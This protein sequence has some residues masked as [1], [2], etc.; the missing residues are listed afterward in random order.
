ML[1]IPSFKVNKTGT[2]LVVLVL[3]CTYI[4]LG[5]FLE[6]TQFSLFLGLYF[7]AFV[8]S[9]F[10]YIKHKNNLK[11]LIGSSLLFRILL[12]AAIPNLSQDF[13]RFIWDGR[14]L[15]EGLNPYITT[16]ESW[17]ASHNFPIAQAQELYNGMGDLNGSHYTN[18]PPLHQF[19]F[20]L[21]ALFSQTSI[22]GAVIV[23]KSLLIL[24][25][26]GIFYFGK[27]V[28]I[29]LNRPKPFIFLYLINPFIIL[30]LVGNLHFEALMIFF[31]IWSLYL[32]FSE[33][34]I[35]SAIVLGLAVSVKLIP[36]LF[37]PLFYSWFNPKKN[38]LF[39]F[40]LFG[41]IA[42]ITTLLLF[43][44]F[45]SH[46]FIENYSNSV[47]LWFRN[48]EFNASIYYIAREI[49][50]LISGYNLI[51]VIGKILPIITI[52]FVLFLSFKNKTSNAKSIINKLLFGL[53][54]YYFLSTTVHPWYL[55]TLVI[56]GIFTT[57]RF[58]LVWSLVVILSYQA[59][60]KTPFQENLILIGV[61]YIIVF[62]FLFYEVISKIKFNNKKELA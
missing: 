9:Y 10:L 20:F 23:M 3:C 56:L 11:I 30:E 15:L 37:I 46:E 58:P 41:C 52:C 8:F 54:F 33:K 62:G 21:A 22:L 12:I 50:Y 34:W 28:L 2:F 55:S 35:A 4:Y 51:S 45:L 59:Y 39:K 5:Y 6:R 38:G 26:L 43:A 53:S 32:M 61:E 40:L 42:V 19:G 16:P 18:Y 60:E 29:K 17:I 49:G 1:A 47:G 13:Y 24:A 31:I 48:F 44:P 27:K 14:M 25:D 57:Y 36:L 7:F